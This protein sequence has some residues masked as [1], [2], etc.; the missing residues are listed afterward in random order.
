MSQAPSKSLTES[1]ELSGHLVVL[2]M[3]V[4]RL[5]QLEAGTYTVSS[6]TAFRQLSSLL[7]RQVQHQ[8]APFARGVRF[9]GDTLCAQLLARQEPAGS[10]TPTDRAMM[11]ASLADEFDVLSRL[12]GPAAFTSR[13]AGLL[14]LLS[15]AASELSVRLQQDVPPGCIV[16]P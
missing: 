12:T 2:S 14:A 7:E 5:R 11:L 8:A 1:L 10:A 4:Y 16:H 6:H 9:L 15:S 13:M 3:A